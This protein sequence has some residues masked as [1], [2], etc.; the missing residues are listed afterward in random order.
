MKVI[1][2]N[3]FS[4]VDGSFTRTSTATYIDGGV[5]KTAAV[6]EPRF[7]DGVLLLEGQGTNRVRQSEDLTISPWAGAVSGSSTRTDSGSGLA[8]GKTFLVTATSAQGGIRQSVSGLTAGKNYTWSF[9]IESSATTLVFF[10]ENGNAT[11]GNSGMYTVFNPANGEFSASV[12]GISR[13]AVKT[14]NAWYITIVL[15]P[16]AALLVA[17]LE[18]R[19]PTSGQ[20]FLLSQPQFE[21][22]VAKSSYIP[23][24]TTAVTRSP[25][26]VN[27]LTRA[28]T[29]TYIDGGVLKT[30]AV[31]EA[32]YQ[33]GVL[34][35]ETT[36]TNLLTYSEQFDNGVWNKVRSSVVTNSSTAPNGA[37][38]AALL[39]E[40]TTASAT[41]YTQVAVSVN[42][43]NF[44]TFSTFVKSLN[45]NVELRLT[46]GSN[47]AVTFD[48]TSKTGSAT[49]GLPSFS[50]TE[51]SSGWLKVSISG[52]SD[53]TGVVTARLSIINGSANAYT[54]DG[55]SGLYL[56]GAQFEQTSTPS[57]YTPT[58]TAPVTRA[59]DTLFSG[60]IYS[61][62]TE[63]YSAWSSGTTYS[64]G[65]KVLYNTH[66][67]ESLQNSNTNQNPLT[68][69]TFWLDLGADNRHAALD[70]KIGTVTEATE[71]FSMIVSSNKVDS[72]T[73]LN[74]D[75]AVCTV[76]VYDL[77]TYAQIYSNT[78]GTSGVDVNDWY[79]YFFFDPLSK[80]TQ[81]VLSGLGAL[82]PNTIIAIK[83][84]GAAADTVKL[85]SL[86][87]GE[88]ENLGATQYAP[89]VGIVD[90]SKKEV[91]QFGNVSITERPFS[92][93]LSTDVYF[94]NYDLNRIQRF[95]YSIR[96]KPVVWIASEDPTYE[97]ALVV[98]GFYK[99]FSTTIAYPS[100][101]LCNLEIEGLT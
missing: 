18:I 90:Y 46:F 36:G 58:T 82:Y 69:A 6:N 3:E 16:A 38:L 12:G 67:Y 4:A 5:L 55:S 25:D 68:A 29:A 47:V 75:T 21:E 52:V 17:H 72:I 30:A 65:D 9:K 59:A 40:D 20:S 56:W 28:S 22:G 85:G 10:L 53:I 64:L 74:L 39:R 27:S 78:F 100:H 35:V 23:T 43:G 8:V 101:S 79:Q 86:L 44:Y 11:Y 48:L 37:T 34:L 83:L 32:R 42:T 15:Q 93:R 13:F 92:K 61:T 73:L 91:D 71:T 19:I 26:I 97:E 2:P 80:R 45:R 66:I 96:A 77:K 89:K 7:Q 14:G 70:A 51:L 63:S 98:Y 50:I 94:P 81:V 24:T 57:S 31:N 41:H 62:A 60:L 99:D 33:D 87:V 1:K 76:S 88:T 84:T 49:Q 54:G 95:L